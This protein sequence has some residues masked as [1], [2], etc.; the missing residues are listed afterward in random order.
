MPI[1]ITGVA[2]GK[3]SNSAFNERNLKGRGPATVDSCG[4]HVFPKEPVPYPFTVAMNFIHS[5]FI[6]KG[7]NKA[8]VQTVP[9]TNAT[10][11]IL[12][13]PVNPPTIMIDIKG[14][15]DTDE[16]KALGLTEQISVDFPGKW[17]MSSSMSLENLRKLWDLGINHKGPSLAGNVNPAGLLSFYYAW[18]A[19]GVYALTLGGRKDLAMGDMLFVDGGIEDPQELK[20]GIHVIGDN[21]QSVKVFEVEEKQLDGDNKVYPSQRLAP[22]IAPI[23]GIYTAARFVSNTTDPIDEEGLL[24]EYF[25]EMLLPNKDFVAGVFFRYFSRCIVDKIEELEGLAP[26]LR[27]GFV[28]LQ[29]SDAGKV[30]QHVYYGIQCSVETGSKLRIIVD[31]GTYRGFVLIGGNIAVLVDGVLQNPIKATKLQREIAAMDIHKAAVGSIIE[32]LAKLEVKFGENSVVDQEKA[33]ESSRYLANEIHRRKVAGDSEEEISLKNSIKHLRYGDKYWEMNPAN[34][35][36]ITRCI[37]TGQIADSEPFYLG[38]D[39]AFSDNILI[40]ILSVFGPLAPTLSTR[41]GNK[42]I[43]LS[44]P[45]NDDPNLRIE[46]NRTKVPFL[47][48]YSRGLGDAA[49]MWEQ[50]R[51]TKVLKIMAAKAKGQGKFADR[52]T[53]VGHVAGKEFQDLY[54][55]LRTWAHAS[56]GSQKR[57]RDLTADEILEESVKLAKKRALDKS[58]ASMF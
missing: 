50:L 56:G 23:S 45:G 30:L 41:N 14:V 18:K 48:I 53:D 57:G 29:T 26:M 6:S 20:D 12:V 38:T 3:L 28:D 40:R 17:M 13:C 10:K 55:L 21:T 15:S 7:V 46:A 8:S 49:D 4:I 5:F 31:K 39:Y 11:R 27:R 24:F 9:C 36:K 33:L 22:V 37:T 47:P 54:S 51:R 35:L 44:P 52:S 25:D 58:V 42:N 19:V 32:T 1:F 43:A 2:S 34:V 16:F